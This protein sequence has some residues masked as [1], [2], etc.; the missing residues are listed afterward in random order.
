MHLPTGQVYRWYISKEPSIFFMK[1]TQKHLFKRWEISIIEVEDTE[2]SKFKVTRRIADYSVAET[3]FF[4][5]KKKAKQ[6][7]EQWLRE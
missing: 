5:S 6:Q 3:K 1:R 7:F 4:T 2:G